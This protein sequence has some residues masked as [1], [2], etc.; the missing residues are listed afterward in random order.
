[1]IF[2]KLFGYL[3]ILIG[4]AIVFYALYASY[5]IFTGKMAVPEIFSAPAEKISSQT[6]TQDLQKQ[7]EEIVKNQFKD[8]LPI[9]TLPKMLNLISW[10]ILAGIL[11]LG[12]GKISGIGIRLIATNSN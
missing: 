2:N 1:M 5:E 4:L 10:S 6:G 11:I 12:G 3:V 7:M 8:L 9:D